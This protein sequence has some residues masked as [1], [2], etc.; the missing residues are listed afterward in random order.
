MATTKNDASKKV[1]YNGYDLGF[2]FVKSVFKT[3]KG[4]Y[5]QIFPTDIDKANPHIE[6]IDKNPIILSKPLD[7]ILSF[8]ADNTRFTIGRGARTEFTVDQFEMLRPIKDLQLM[9]LGSLAMSSL[10]YGVTDFYIAYVV[11]IGL[12]KTE[13]ER[14]AN[15]VGTHEVLIHGAIESKVNI[16]V[17][18]M[19]FV[20]QGIA[21]LFDLMYDFNDEGKIV[22]KTT[23]G[24]VGLVDIGTNT[25]NV[26]VID[27]MKIVHK[28][29][30]PKS[31]MYKFIHDF[32]Q[33]LKSRGFNVSKSDIQKMITEN[34][35]SIKH[36]SPDTFQ[37]EVVDLNDIAKKIKNELFN[38]V[39]RPR[40]SNL[41]KE[42]PSIDKIVFTGGGVK[43]F[44]QLNNQQFIVPADP[45]FSNAIGA[46]K[47]LYLR[48]Q[49]KA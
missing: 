48:R 28:E 20:E 8:E 18:Y 4:F 26:A 36:I 23:F 29:T 47:M 14:W 38:D 21:S 35:F 34:N 44:P 24:K 27:N 2:G 43:V 22:Q 19:S 7:Q 5:K 11:P 3:S 10:Q 41:L 25:V 33:E 40:I 9:L 1:V 16:K 32:L 39:I 17:K 30:Y 31:G 45:Q 13:K 37:E 12:T 42:Y 49:A 46:L 6:I 15:F